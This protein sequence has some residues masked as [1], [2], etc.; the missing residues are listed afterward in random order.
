MLNGIFLLCLIMTIILIAM[1]L[2]IL[3]IGA[4]KRQKSIMRASYVWFAVNLLLAVLVWVLYFGKLRF[5]A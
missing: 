3:C 4:V 5:L 2:L 1:P